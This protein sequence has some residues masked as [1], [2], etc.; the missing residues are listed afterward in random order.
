[1]LDIGH[2]KLFPSANTHFMDLPLDG[3]PQCS[4]NAIPVFWIIFVEHVL[5]CEHFQSTLRYFAIVF[6]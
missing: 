2:K 1:M 5:N 4:S 6:F 3:Y